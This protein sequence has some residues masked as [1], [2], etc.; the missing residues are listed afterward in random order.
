MKIEYFM[1]GEGLQERRSVWETCRVQ[2]PGCAAEMRASTR[3]PQPLPSQLQEH[4]SCDIPHVAAVEAAVM[5]VLGMAWDW[6]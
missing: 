2:G 4:S 1:T 6:S 3:K 5:H